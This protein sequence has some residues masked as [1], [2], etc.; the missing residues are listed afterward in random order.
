MSKQLVPARRA[1]AHNCQHSEFSL[2]PVQLMRQGLS[3]NRFNEAVCPVVFL[4]LP[5]RAQSS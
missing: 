1:M 5:R 2:G 4:L 3:K